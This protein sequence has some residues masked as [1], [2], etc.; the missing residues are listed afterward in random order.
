MDGPLGKLALFSTY[1]SLNFKKM[2]HCLQL[3]LL[4]ISSIKKKDYRFDDCVVKALEKES[5]NTIGCTTPF[6]TKKDN[7]CKNKTDGMK[8]FKL[9]KKV[10]GGK[11]GPNYGSCLE[12]CS[13]MSIKLIT[14]KEWG[15]NA[16]EGILW[17]LFS[18]K[19]TEIVAYHSYDSLSF[20]AEIGGYVGLFLG[21][22]V[23]QIADLFQSMI[24][25]LRNY[26]SRR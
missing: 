1:C 20:I 6:V 25:I 21:A 8:A 24:R 9:Y 5:V 11:F 3:I 19:V 23:Y 2:A 16:S 26:L 10:T 14:S 15:T 7:I 12:S 4:S 17:L 18:E 22:S 13:F